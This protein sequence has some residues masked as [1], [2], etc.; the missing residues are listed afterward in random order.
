MTGSAA[1]RDD[2]L[3]TL[4]VH[5]STLRVPSILFR[6]LAEL[7]GGGRIADQTCRRVALQPCAAQ[8]VEERATLGLKR[9]CRRGDRSASTN[10]TIW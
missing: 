2:P 5:E 9:N 4:R 6:T 1:E 3:L 7:S 10:C 8:V